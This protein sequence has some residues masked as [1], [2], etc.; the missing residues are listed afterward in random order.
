MMMSW[1]YYTSEPNLP[2]YLEGI[3]G[4]FVATDRT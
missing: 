3:R 4:K 2:V 1:Q